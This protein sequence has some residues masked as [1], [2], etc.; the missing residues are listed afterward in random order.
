M[1]QK[2]MTSSMTS[3][4]SHKDESNQIEA[5]KNKNHLIPSPVQFGIFRG[6]LRFGTCRQPTQASRPAGVGVGPRSGVGRRET[7]DGV[8]SF[9]RKRPQRVQTLPQLFGDQK[10]CLVA[11]DQGDHSLPIWQTTLLITI[12]KLCWTI[13]QD[14]K[15][16]LKS[17]KSWYL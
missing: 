5:W 12:L 13:E 16:A 17:L 10:S 3:F 14:R 2:S 8:R 15:A 9:R 1:P 11:V 6:L 4:L 7:G